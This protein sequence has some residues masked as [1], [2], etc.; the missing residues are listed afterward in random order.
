LLSLEDP[1]DSIQGLFAFELGLANHESILRQA[2][3]AKFEGIC[4]IVGHKSELHRYN[5]W[6]TFK[7]KAD[8]HCEMKHYAL[9]AARISTL[10]SSAD[11]YASWHYQ[12]KSYIDDR[13]D[14]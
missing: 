3:T 9:V 13:H 2:L 12:L 14:K 4:K 7:Q 1:F 11:F 8:A 5:M 6:D 10:W